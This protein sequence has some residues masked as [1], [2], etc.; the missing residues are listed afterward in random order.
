MPE[1]TYRRLGQVLE[2]LGFSGSVPEPG[3]KLYRHASGALVILPDFPKDD[4]VY[5][6]QLVGARMILDAYGIADPPEFTSRLQKAG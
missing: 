6:H 4:V 2:S 5:P 1:V 3:T